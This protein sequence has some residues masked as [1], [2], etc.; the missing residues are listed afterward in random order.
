MVRRHRHRRQHGRGVSGNADRFDY[1][2][3]GDYFP[4]YIPDYI[5]DTSIGAT[6]R[7]PAAAA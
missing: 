7:P 3:F 2:S 1:V 6:G 4:D 5:P